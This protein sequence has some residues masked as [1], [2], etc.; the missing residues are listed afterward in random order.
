MTKIS[1]QY[2]L[3]NILTADLANSRLGINNVSPTVALDVT[4]AGRFS[5]TLQSN[6]GFI[7]ANQTEIFASAGASNRAYAFSVGNVA[8]GDFTISQGSTATG[9]TYTTRLTI[10]P[11]GNVGIGTTSPSTILHVNGVPNQ[12]TAALTVSLTETSSSAAA[13]AKIAF[14]STNT[15]Y[16]DNGTCQIGYSWLA[17]SFYFD[18]IG[19]SDVDSF[20]FR[21][22]TGGSVLQRMSIANNGVV[23]INNLGSGAV[24]A[25]SGVLS[26]T[27]DMTLKVDDGYIDNALEKISQLKPRYFYWKEESGLPTDIRQLG[28]YAQEVN[29]AL[30][31]EAANTPK[32]ENDKWGIY[33]RGIIAM[34]TKAIQ[35]LSAKVSLLE[36]K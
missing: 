5:S 11:S 13:L 27:S 32:N 22:K 8:A 3:T 2:S 12:S 25:T 28:F 26:T 19:R 31:E 9:G 35:E 6:G 10:N 15:F 29:Q 1:N 17:G 30:G 34:L 20:T 4:G 7:Q 16:G 36:N 21:T 23:T 33:D 14:T 18:A 24:T